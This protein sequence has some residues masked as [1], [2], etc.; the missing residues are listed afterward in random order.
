VA[1]LLTLPT[2]GRAQN[3]GVEWPQFRGPNRDGGVPA[4]TEPQSWPNQLTRKWTVNVGEGYAT[5]LIVGDRVYMFARQGTNE[6][7]QALDANTGKSLWQT[8]YAAP[9]TMNPAAVSHGP[10]P[11]STPAFASGR[12]YTLGMGGIVTAF[13]AAS[14]KQL[15]QSR[16]RRSCPITARRCRRSSMAAW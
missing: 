9:V 10:G 2:I 1:L 7:M 15:W 8:R 13:D 16:R 12:L 6:V 11:K 4:F 5:P 3:S 14:G